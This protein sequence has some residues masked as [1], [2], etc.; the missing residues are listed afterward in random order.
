MSINLHHEEQARVE[1]A[2]SRA[3]VQ[4]ARVTVKLVV[5]Q[6]GSA[7]H[8]RL[9]LLLIFRIRLQF[10]SPRVLLGKRPQCRL[11]RIVNKWSKKES[12]CHFHII[13]NDTLFFH[14][15]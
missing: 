11:A 3:C 4:A 1:L 13:L 5:K 8:D 10:R 7:D 2:R 12:S 9:F 15:K 6:P 14:Y